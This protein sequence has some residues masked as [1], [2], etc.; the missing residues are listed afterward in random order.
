MIYLFDLK[1]L[2]YRYLFKP[3]ISS[4]RKGIKFMEEGIPIEI[5]QVHVFNTVR[6]FNL[7]LGI[8]RPLLNSELLQK[9][10]LHSSDMDY[11]EFYKKFVPKTHLPSDYGGTLESVEKLH[12]KSR[13]KLENLKDYF[14]YEEQQSNLEFDEFVDEFFEEM[15]KI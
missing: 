15:N 2:S 14:I 4:M 8:V 5:K 11:E 13:E 10:H 1:G 6:F 12:E 9:L 7:I 3:S